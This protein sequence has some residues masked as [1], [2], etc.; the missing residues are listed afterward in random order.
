M[1]KDTNQ[2]LLFGSEISAPIP[3]RT[4]ATSAA[5]HV[6]IVILALIV[7]P[8]AVTRDVKAPMKLV[9]TLLA[10]TPVKPYKPEPPKVRPPKLLAKSEIVPKPVPVPLKSQ[11][12]PVIPPPVVKEIPKPIPQP[13][14]AA[15]E[16]KP[17]PRVPIPE[18]AP[19]S[20]IKPQVH[21]GVFGSEQAAKKVEAARDLKVGGFGDPNGVKTSPETR[22][23]NLIA[24]VGSFEAP[25]GEGTAG[26]RGGA[27]RGTVRQTSFGAMEGAGSGP[28][29]NGLGIGHGTVRQSGFGAADGGGGNGTGGN[30]R[31]GTVKTGGFGETAAAASQ[32]VQ[33]P[34]AIT[35]N[36]TPVE[37]LSKPKPVY[38]PEARS[39]RLEGEVSLEV[40]FSASGSVQVVRVIQ[41]LGHGLDEAAQTAA[42][43]IRFKP[44]TRDGAP[45]D[46]RATIRIVFEL[47]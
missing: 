9:T 26:G 39:L 41:G 20:A 44:G 10:P 15:A 19:A 33:R 24:K 11:P 47:T 43:H 34:K 45:V 32:P 42:S 3:W 46:T 36:T 1:S 37:I 6:G 28:G 8:M 25:Q 5:V 30:G 16:P 14:I 18:V 22:N 4:Y 29:G 27:G 21:T 38:T 35:P 2:S 31:G 17:I 23:N 40:V 13:E 7:I 12:K